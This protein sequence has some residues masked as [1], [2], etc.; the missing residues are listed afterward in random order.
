MSSLLENDL[1][2]QKSGPPSIF[3]GGRLLPP[4][5][6]LSQLGQD[7]RFCGLLQIS[8]RPWT[9]RVVLANWGRVLRFSRLL[10]VL[11]Y[12]VLPLDIG[13]TDRVAGIH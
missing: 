13:C 7:K 10:G 11:S 8:E 4:A 3:H 1:L 9:V 2:E 6:R 12:E 5:Q